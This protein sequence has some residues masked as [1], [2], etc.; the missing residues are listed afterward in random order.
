MKVMD[1][2]HKRARKERPVQAARPRNLRSKEESLCRRIWLQGQTVVTAVF[3][4]MAVTHG[5][6]H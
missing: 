4:S 6:T 2:G 3:K 1:R 5:E